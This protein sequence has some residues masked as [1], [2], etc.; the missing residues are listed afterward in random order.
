MRSQESAVRPKGITAVALV[1]TL[2][3]FGGCASSQAAQQQPTSTATA[4]RAEGAGHEHGKQAGMMEMC[5]MRVPGATVSVADTEGGVAVVFKTTG[6]VAELRRRVRHMAEM[7]NRHHAEGTMACCQGM[8]GGGRDAGATPEQGGRGMMMGGSHAGMV[9]AM[10]AAEDVEGGARIVLTP[11][12]SAQLGALRTHVRDHAER[13][14]RGEC[15]MMMM[16]GASQ[17]SE[18]QHER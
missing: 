15:P 13:M 18:H 17:S 8:M 2:A 5:P 14:G 1:L 16:G 3:A 6:D 11:K 12:D 4:S 10:A 7:H 9:P